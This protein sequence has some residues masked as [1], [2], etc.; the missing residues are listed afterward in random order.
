[1][2]GKAKTGGCLRAYCIYADP[3]DIQITVHD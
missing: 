2:T 1:L 3:G